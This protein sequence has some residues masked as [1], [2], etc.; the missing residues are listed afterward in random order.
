M[1]GLPVSRN[2]GDGQKA[3]DQKFCFSCGSVLHFSAPHCP[4]CGAVQ[5]PGAWGAFPGVPNRNEPASSSATLPNH[6]FCRGCGARIH[7]SALSCP[8]CGAAQKRQVAD[9]VGGGAE[10]VTAAMLAIFLG[11]VG[12]HK[13]YLGKWGQGLVCLIFCWTFIP[14][15]IGII[16]GILYLAMSEGEFSRRYS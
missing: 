8:K 14:A 1:N 16:E 13:F 2:V 9:S 7:E 12:L 5:P 4:K 15:V 10:R 3:A 6:A 11:G